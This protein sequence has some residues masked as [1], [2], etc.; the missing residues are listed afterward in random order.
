[1]VKAEYGE[2]LRAKAATLPLTP[3]VYIMRDTAGKVIYVGKSRT[4]KNRVSGY[5]QESG[6]N[7]LKTDTMTAHIFDFDYILC[8]TEM[9]ALTLENS[10]I[11]LYHPR[12]NIKLKDDKSYPYLK[13][14]LGEEFPRFVMT[15][16]RESEKA[17]Y[18]GPYTSTATVY[19]IIA[20]LQKTFGLPSCK[21]SFPKDRGRVKS[22]V[23]KQ[24]GCTA[25]CDPDVTAE[26]YR[27]TFAEAV[28]FLSGDYEKIVENMT[29]KMNYAA[30]N[31]A[32]EAAAAYRDRIRAVKK[33]EEKQKVVASPDT[34]RDIIAWYVGDPISAICIFYIRFGKLID[35]EMFYFSGG[36]IL[37]SDAVTAF[38][39]E[40]YSR[41]EYI[42]KEVNPAEV[43]SPEDAE[44]LSA[45]LTEK[46]GSRIYVRTPFKGEVRKLC[47]MAGENAK[48]R[49]AEYAKMAEK[50]EKS[51]V[52][53]AALCGLESVP[54]RIEA[55]DISNFGDDNITAGM[56]VY[57]DAKPKK[58]DY[59]LFN[60]RS[61]QSRDDYASMREAISRRVAHLSDDG[62]V[63]PDLLLIDGGEVHRA[64]AA[65][66][67]SAAGYDIP[68]FGMVKDEYHKTRALVGENGE[69]SIA[70]EQSVYMLIYNIQ[71]EV[72]RF[73][74][75]K[76]SAAK[77]K[78]QTTSVL[79]EIPGIGKA[80]AKA[81]L[82][83]F[84]GLAGVKKATAKELCAI[85]G[86]TPE[87]A[88]KI[89]SYFQQNQS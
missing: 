75:S 65:E 28:A 73:T 69:I 57:E 39:Y 51:L 74:V 44:A 77:R 40:L 37:D 34:E 56:V 84:G 49:S 6:Q 9:E 23:Y 42:P 50:S 85:R 79:E 18:F 52:R 83:H 82:M 14:T 29:E 15:R 22:C 72:H 61:T 16:K 13:A 46:A 89:I 21:Y 45:W 47:D 87:V 81:L 2:R 31:L 66:E 32:F 3:G 55:F 63:V 38:L 58:S 27:E 60:I 71:E 12:Y 26:Q 10:L 86:V 41:R 48:I 30:E 78:T 19:G 20:A 88:E 43:L 35:S 17:K 7:S 1:M 36:E 54:A 80:R 4:I 76:M 24:M 11:K 68:V 8:D 25:P 67:V 5:F 62:A 53:L 64:I 33:L 70:A 59:R